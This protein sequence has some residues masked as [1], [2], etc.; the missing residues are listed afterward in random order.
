MRRKRNTYLFLLVL[1][2][3]IG[4]GF[5]IQRYFFGKTGATAIIEQDG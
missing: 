2:A 3:N 1:L 5:L 4:V